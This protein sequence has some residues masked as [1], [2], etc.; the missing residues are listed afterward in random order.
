MY[1]PGELINLIFT[2]YNPYKDIFS[3]VLCEMNNDWVDCFYC[4]EPIKYNM[5]NGNYIFNEYHFHN[6]NGEMWLMY[7]IQ[8]LQPIL[9]FRQKSKRYICKDHSKCKYYGLEYTCNRF[10]I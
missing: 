10:Y 1:L 7:D 4:Q 5:S 3:R 2:F 6:Y 8:G 9:N